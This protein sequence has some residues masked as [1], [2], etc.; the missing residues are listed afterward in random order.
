MANE[1]TAENAEK[2]PVIRSDRDGICELMLND[3]AKYNTLSTEALD[4]MGATLADIALDKTVR[5]VVVAARGK[6]FCS[7]HNLKQMRANHGEAYYQ[8]LLADCSSMMQDIVS[9]PQPVIAK[10]Q[11]IATAAGCQLVA[12]CDLAIAGRSARFATN[13]INNGLFCALPAVAVGRTVARKHALEMLLTGEFIDADRAASIGLINHAVD[14]ADLDAAVE[15]LAQDLS[16]KSQYAIRLGKASF[17]RQI[18]QP[19][20][21]A[22]RSASND[23]V[24][25]L[26][27]D[28]GIEGVDAFIE[29]REPHW[30]N[31]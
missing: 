11:G 23:L 9:L 26:L 2:F 27:S 19:L 28:D 31:E 25:N 12:S 13:G 8:K 14:D 7:G 1:N 4:S 5:V 24:C 30:N 29:N 16:R 22:Y 15:K 18:D 20:D 17:Q 6:A 3:P 10:V 21:A